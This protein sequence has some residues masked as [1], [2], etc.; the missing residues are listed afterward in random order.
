MC[1]ICGVAYPN[2]QKPDQNL[3]TKMN[4]TIAHRGP[5]SDGYYLNEGIGLAI[6]RLA[7]IDVSGGDQ[8]ITNED[9]SKWIVFNGECYNYPTMRAELEKRG[10]HFR[11]QTDT[12]CILHFYEDEGDDCIQHLHGMFAFA[13]WDHTQ[14][15]LLIGRDRI[16][17][18]PLFY[19]IQNE[20]LYFGSELSTILTALPHKPEI[21][22]EALDLYLSLQY[23]PDPLTIYKGIFKLPPAHTLIWHQGKIQVTKYWD[24]TYQP[25]W[26]AS[27]DELIEELQSRLRQSVKKRLLSERPI[28][29]HLSGGIDSS[30]IVALMAEFSDIPVKTFSVGFEEQNFSELPYARAVAE[31]YATQHHEFMLTYGDIPTTLEKIA[32]HFGEPFADASAIPLY[33]LSILTR[34][35][36]TV[37]LNGDGG[38]ENF[39][40]YQRYWLDQL[41]N[42]Y[43]QAPQI[44]T[45]NLIPFMLH[46]LPDKSDRPSGQSLMNGLK[47]LEQLPQIDKRASI[48]R[49]SSYFSP[50]HRSQ[51]W[52]KEYWS[53]LNANNAQSLLINSFENTSG[54]YLDKTLYTDLHNYLP[55]DLL[56]KADRM[57]MAASLEG[58]SPF[59]DHTLVEWTARIPNQF[60]TRGRNGKYLLKK[61]FAKQLPPSI[62][63]RN[64]Q[65]FGIPVATWFRGPLLNWATEILSDKNSC[66]STWFHIK[67][68]VN[69]I[70]EHASGKVDHSKRL[71]ALTM[72]AVWEKIK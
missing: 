23:I 59:L 56:V 13:L 30:I 25:K 29:A 14:K 66:L 46:F 65:G 16:G 61:A 48:L 42:I 15:R 44:L 22:L 64:K 50:L 8:P 62:Q 18:K 52:Q 27:E 12:E 53:Q 39:A 34:E 35:H 6:R 63:T 24:L 68:M 36:V 45:R 43:T 1:G 9:K 20:T 26:T 58:R 37:A 10:H 55:G 71:Y 69:L 31:K 3:L 38:D 72:L 7:I 32:S 47:R 4:N 54:S 57:T 2:N 11:T 5:D 19:T 40:G 33:H 49:W 17:K 41:A 67:Y 21:N 60:K 51:L 28:G 70:Q